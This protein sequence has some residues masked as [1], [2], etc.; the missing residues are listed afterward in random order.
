MQSDM[1]SAN[2]NH[3]FMAGCMPSVRYGLSHDTLNLLHSSLQ[4]VSSG[5]MDVDSCG[6]RQGGQIK[7]TQLRGD[8]F[9]NATCIPELFVNRGE[10]CGKLG[11]S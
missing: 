8:H 3:V 4:L 10:D 5:F 6:P 11:W 9:S 2:A 1:F 7:F